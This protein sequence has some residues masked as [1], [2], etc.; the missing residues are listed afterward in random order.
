MTEPAKQR[1]FPHSHNLMMLL[2]FDYYNYEFIFTNNSSKRRSFLF[3]ESEY[4]VA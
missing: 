4:D 3:K 2:F 1:Y